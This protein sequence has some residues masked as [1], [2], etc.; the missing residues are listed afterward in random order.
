[1]KRL[2]IHLNKMCLSHRE[3]PITVANQRQLKGRSNKIA[4]FDA[5][6]NSRI[7]L[8]M[9]L[10][11]VANFAKPSFLVADYQLEVSCITSLHST[12]NLELVITLCDSFQIIKTVDPIKQ[13][14]FGSIRVRDLQIFSIY[15]LKYFHFY[16]SQR[17]DVCC[18]KIEIQCNSEFQVSEVTTIFELYRI[19][20]YST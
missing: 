5:A 20:L 12:V 8:T 3:L 15:Y 6:A 9:F 1:M 19:Y 11:P 4:R 18:E 2:T 7:S 13:I 16:L 10:Q 14:R 17:P